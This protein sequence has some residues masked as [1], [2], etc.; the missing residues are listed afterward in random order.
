MANDLYIIEYCINYIQHRLKYGPDLHIVILS[1]STFSSNALAERFCEMVCRSG[2][3]M[4]TLERMSMPSRAILRL[5]NTLT[6]SNLR[7]LRLSAI[8]LH[9]TDAEILVESL[10]SSAVV[11]LDLSDNAIG[12][13]V[14]VRLIYPGCK[15]TTLNIASTKLGQPGFERLCSNLVRYDVHLLTL[16]VSRNNICD[17]SC[18]AGPIANPGN[19]LRTLNLSRNIFSNLTALRKVIYLSRSIASI[20]LSQVK[21]L[22]DGDIVATFLDARNPVTNVT[23]GFVNLEGT[24]ISPHVR[25]MLSD[26]LKRTSSWRSR[27]VIALCTANVPRLGARSSAVKRLPTDIVRVVAEFLPADQWST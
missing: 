9:V 23:L 22:A 10:R 16:D 15:L 26:R 2:L 4:L 5:A 8:G 1:N 3:T 27:V 17:V 14:A 12:P 11:S 19:V 25:D 13:S 18:A 20:N 21:S 6:T 7:V 24:L